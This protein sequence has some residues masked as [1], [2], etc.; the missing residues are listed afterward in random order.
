MK[1][2][3]SFDIMIIRFLLAALHLK[4]VL[5]HKNTKK[6][7][8]AVASLPQGLNN[9]YEAEMKRIERTGDED[10][11]IARR[12]LSWVYFAKLSLS[13]KQ[14]QEAIAVDPIE[15]IEDIDEECRDLNPESL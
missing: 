6:R 1:T 9:A 11:E 12:A 13:M 10:Y 7:K 3:H 4:S 5:E 14:L 8:K 15:N 2:P